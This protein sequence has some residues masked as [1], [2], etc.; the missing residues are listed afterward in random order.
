[1]KI[2]KEEHR[3]IAR[4]SFLKAA[5]DSG[6]SIGMYYYLKPLVYDFIETIVDDKEY[7]SAEPSS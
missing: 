7:V 2:T 6:L 5:S 3:K 1:M 4:E